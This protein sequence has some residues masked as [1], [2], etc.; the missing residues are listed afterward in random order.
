ML[1]LLETM[2]LLLETATIICKI[3]IKAVI[4][5]NYDYKLTLLLEVSNIQVWYYISVKTLKF[6]VV[7]VN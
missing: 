2:L 7:W 4:I 3:T 5:R 1:L 6:E